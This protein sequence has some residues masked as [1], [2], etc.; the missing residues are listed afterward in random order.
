VDVFLGRIATDGSVTSARRFG[1][2]AQEKPY[3]LGVGA[4][5]V[6][7]GGS[8]KGAARLGERTLTS[9]GEGFDAFVLGV[10]R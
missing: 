8:F 6:F 5:Q 7:L 10:E 4:T 2:T 3:A 1:A 9:A